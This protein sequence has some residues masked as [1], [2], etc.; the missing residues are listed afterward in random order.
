[1]ENSRNGGVGWENWVQWQVLVCALIFV[2]P[3]VVAVIILV[4]RDRA[5]REP[6]LNSGDLWIPCWRNL[7]P[8]WLLFYRALAF[9]FMALLLYQ[10]VASFGAF[11]FYFYTQWTFALVMVYF[12]LGTIISARGC[13]IM[14]SLK[15][16]VENEEG[17]EFLNKTTVN[18]R[19]KQIKGSYNHEEFEQRAGFWEYLMQIIYQVL[20]S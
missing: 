17:D 18:S 11:V 5:N 8:L 1:M 13:W 14:Y 20:L 19:V 12:G 7:N 9:S 6:P 15:P 10:I 3:C 4:N 2:V 16:L